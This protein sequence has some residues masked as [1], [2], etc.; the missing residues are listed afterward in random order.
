MKTTKQD[1]LKF[2]EISKYIEPHNICDIDKPEI[3]ENL[4]SNTLEENLESLQNYICEMYDNTRGFLEDNELLRLY[5]NIYRRV[6]KNDKKR[7]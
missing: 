6:H 7:I 4:M 3:I 1:A 2:Y 5:L